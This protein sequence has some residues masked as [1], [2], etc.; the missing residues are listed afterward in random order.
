VDPADGFGQED[1]DVDG[2]DL[3]TLQLLQVMGNG[4]C[5]YNLKKME[6]TVKPELTTTSE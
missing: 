1:G 2:L 6:D 5:H 3:V 4:V